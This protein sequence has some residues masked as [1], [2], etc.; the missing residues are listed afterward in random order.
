MARQLLNNKLYIL[1]PLLNLAAFYSLDQ[2]PWNH[3]GVSESK[4]E[5]N[6][7]NENTD[8]NEIDE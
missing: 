4:D 8:E 7:S 2:S 5:T 1:F 6:N 3:V